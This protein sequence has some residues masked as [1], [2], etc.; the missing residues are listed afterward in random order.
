MDAQAIY[1]YQRNP[2]EQGPNG[3]PRP[4]LKNGGNG[5][6]PG[7]NGTSSLLVRSLLIVVVVLLAWGLFAFFTQSS[8]SSA[9]DVVEVPYST[10]YQQVQ[11][12]NVKDVVFQGQDATGD[13]K[14]AIT[15]PGSN[16]GNPSTHF[17]FTQLPNGD[18]TLTPLLNKYHVDYQAKLAND[19]SV[20]ISILFNI[21][22]WVLILGAIIF[23]LRRASQSQQNIFSFGKSRAK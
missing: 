12:N 14:S 3:S 9:Q 10:F 7:G 15:V 19:N 11:E 16:N 8:N 17:H 20:F 5:G 21:L 4:N 2:N 6:G 18:P 22:P 13:F 1:M 23:I